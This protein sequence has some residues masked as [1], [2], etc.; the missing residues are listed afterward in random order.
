ME[1]IRQYPMVATG[2]VVFVI[3][4]LLLLLFDVP[5]VKET[6]QS[7][8]GIPIQTINLQNV[9]LWAAGATVLWWAF[10]WLQQHASEYLKRSST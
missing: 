3:V 4:A 8:A 10:P 2:S 7:A 5:F 6:Q 9:A 1:Y